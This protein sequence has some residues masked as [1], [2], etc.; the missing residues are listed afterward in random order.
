MNTIIKIKNLN[1]RAI[2]GIN[3]PERLH[4]QDVVINIS[5]EVDDSKAVE[6]DDINLAVDYRTVTKKVIGLV[7]NSSFF[8]LETLC[9]K[10]LKLIIEDAKIISASVCVDKPHSLRFADSVAVE[11][12]FKRQP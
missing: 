8:L 5:M 9:D 7:E 10:I 6:N 1:L 3:G 4:K 2:I 12:S 11:K